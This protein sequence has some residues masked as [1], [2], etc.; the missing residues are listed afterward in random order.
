MQKARLTILNQDNNYTMVAYEG[1]QR[2]RVVGSA[3]TQEYPGI[4]TMRPSR[5][6][7]DN[8]AYG[9]TRGGTRPSDGPRK[10]G[11][12]IMLGG[13]REDSTGASCTEL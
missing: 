4:K 13:S 3:R 5:Q 12:A 11:L 10:K 7:L 9:E 6:A 2:A 8:T 1:D